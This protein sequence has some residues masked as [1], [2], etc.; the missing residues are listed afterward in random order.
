[1]LC[2]CCCFFGDYPARNT[3]LLNPI[4]ALRHT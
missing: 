2:R 1:M 3:S 4:E